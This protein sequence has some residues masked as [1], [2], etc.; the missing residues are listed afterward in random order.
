MKQETQKNYKYNLYKV[1]K[2][3]SD[4]SLFSCKRSEYQKWHFK[5]NILKIKIK[6]KYRNF[7]KILEVF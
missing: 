3:D 6:N 7:E 2:K 5:E 1:V 4:G